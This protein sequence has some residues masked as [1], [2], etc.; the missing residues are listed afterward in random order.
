ML[1]VYK[2]TMSSHERMLAD[3]ISDYDDNVN[4]F[5]SENLILNYESLENV[6]FNAKSVNLVTSENGL[7]LFYSIIVK[8]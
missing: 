7:P 5:Y 8:R 3:L 1:K 6:P 2:T 4:W